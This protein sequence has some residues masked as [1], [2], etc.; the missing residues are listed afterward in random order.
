MAKKRTKAQRSAAAKASWQLRKLKSAKAPTPASVSTAALLDE[1]G[2]THGSF[3][4]HARIAQSL[5]NVM[6]VEPGYAK[7]NA[8]QMEA[9]EMIAHKI[10]RIIAGNPSFNDHWDDIAGYAKLC[11]K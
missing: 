10:G 3:E 1:R 8:E 6:R 5:K 4:T 2:K 9:V 7:L 11:S